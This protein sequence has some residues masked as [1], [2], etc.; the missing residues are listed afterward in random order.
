MKR[1]GIISK[2]NELRTTHLLNQDWARTFF[3]SY[4][5]WKVRKLRD[6]E[7]RYS[8]PD[9]FQNDPILNQP[10]YRC[11]E[12]GQ[13]LIIPFKTPSNTVFQYSVIEDWLLSHHTCP[14][15]E[16]NLQ[17]D[18]LSFDATTYDEMRYRLQAINR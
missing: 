13:F 15:T 5:E 3:S 18:Q 2:I 4:F 10:K 16:E 8:I 14:V 17:A 6:I 9:V 11:A 7:A 1:R 12:S